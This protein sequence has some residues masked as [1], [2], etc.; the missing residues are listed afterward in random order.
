M[1]P[2][3]IKRIK[4]NNN[5][6][7]NNASKN[8][9]EYTVLTPVDTIDANSE[10]IKT[11]E[12]AIN[13]D[14]VKNIAIAGPY[15]S[16]K[17][18]IIKSYLKKHS[19]RMKKSITISLAAFESESK[20]EDNTPIK[21]EALEKDILRQLF[22]RVDHNKIPQSR[23]HRLHK[24][25]LIGV[26]LFVVF[27]IILLSIFF[28][29]ATKRVMGN[30]QTIGDAV[31]LPLISSIVVFLIMVA[32]AIIPLSKLFIKLFSNVQIKEIK[33]LG[34]TS[35]KNDIAVEAIFD[36]NMDEIMYFFEMTSYDLL[37]FEDLDRF[38]NSEIFVKLREINN[39]LNNDE[40]IKR[41]IVFIYAL[42]DDMFK[43]ED[44]TKF[45]DFIIPVIPVMNPTNSGEYL[46]EK[47]I[48]NSEGQKYNI[49]QNY[50]LDVSP[51]I[52]DM[53]ILHNIFNEFV[54]Y[55]KTLCELQGLHLDDEEMLSM[56]IFKNV[57]PKE[58]ADL[59]AEKGIIKEAFVNVNKRKKE[60]TVKEHDNLLS[61]EKDLADADKEILKNCKE[62]KTSMLSAITDWEGITSKININPNIF[63]PKGTYTIQQ[64][65]ED[66]FD[67][68]LLE[69]GKTI[70][71]EYYTWDRHSNSKAL[72][73][74]VLQDY[75]K[76]LTNYK[77]T[78]NNKQSIQKK[79]EIVK[80]KIHEINSYSMKRLIEEYGVSE[81]LSEEVS[82]NKLLTFLLRRG[83]I[84]ENYANYINFFK[85]Q[86][87]TTDDMN[88]ILS[89]KNQKPLSYDYHLS[90]TEMIISRLQEYEFETRAIYNFDLLNTLLSNRNEDDKK[91]NA[92]FSGL[93]NYDV[94]WDFI[95]QFVH[96]GE[97][98]EAFIC[99]L[100]NKCNNLWDYIYNNSSLTYEKQIDFLRMILEYAALDDI[101]KQNYAESI[102][103]FITE[104]DDT[105]K[106]LF[107]TTK[108]VSLSISKMKSIMDCIHISFY[109]LSLDNV[110]DEIIDYIYDNHFYEI[111]KHM[112]SE[113]VRKK[114]PEL[115]DD[116]Y[117]KNYTTIKKIQY[118]PML[119][120]IDCY[121]DQY[122]DK[123]FF[124]AENTK[125]ES[126]SILYF[127][128][129]YIDN[130]DI[131]CRIITHEE[132]CVADIDEFCVN[133][134]VE[135]DN[136]GYNK[137]IW[138][139]IISERK[140]V[141]NWHNVVTYW[142]RF[143]YND[144]L[145]GYISQN[146][147]MLID[148]DDSE[149]TNEFIADI[150]KNKIDS[151]ALEK[152]LTMQR[153]ELSSIPFDK[154][155]DS[156][157]IV[158]VE[159]NYIPFTLNNFDNLKASHP[160][161]CETLILCHQNEFIQM[162]NEVHIDLSLML[163]LLNNDK[164]Q[165]SCKQKLIDEYAVELMSPELAKHILE[166]NY[167]INK[168]I[169]FEALG[170]LEGQEKKNLFMKN[171]ELF[172]ADDF[173]KCFNTLE[174]YYPEFNDRNKSHDVFIDDTNE[175][176]ALAD[177]LK[178]VSY[179][180]SYNVDK[181]HNQIRCTIKSKVLV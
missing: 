30:A 151:S 172:N 95:D 91:L 75:I 12:W 58:F 88:Y 110:P 82:D 73:N 161:T 113:Y 140:I 53:R 10:Y 32:V 123:V 102:A 46:I 176:I 42:K 179:I 146:V 50:I 107:N 19:D 69:S 65:L 128:P 26:F 52:S 83:Y 160:N 44:R 47:F 72:D 35:I 104:K 111:N 168:E 158:L 4:E 38:N 89:I 108:D 80:N 93:S 6:D 125:E 43:N 138:D 157:I 139:Q 137:K 147:N 180:T 62:I 29:E 162:I 79:I 22:Y 78:A 36:M 25:N 116:I 103:S 74:N 8:T 41:R 169:F 16:G 27:L 177:A 67:L 114:A 40:N 132:F 1:A 57:Y 56:I 170:F 85:A 17:S 143:G 71:V 100:S 14:S 141:S 5:K 135:E 126:D 149:I 18:S 92:F 37:F 2:N 20:I 99:I 59:Q 70:N 68:S 163:R 164:L 77:K 9:M 61:Y 117:I 122:M 106:M 144:I 7:K 145:I 15:G 3:F 130:D 118:Q 159:L 49:S 101:V 90:M 155:P 171:L 33:T 21:I 133:L 173:E 94:S 124:S 28:L 48:N 131:R 81:V 60:F 11:L 45:F 166:N 120:H 64:I 84:N 39:L 51:Y 165:H 142:N 112:I 96:K 98:K 24:I 136:D 148:S 178:K 34:D 76:R 167:S 23:Y 129:K 13:N 181:E 121:L 152:V 86:S 63:Q 54:L 154:I 31:G 87:M 105:L 127:I 109:C 150:V 66:S 115:L 175:N 97:N 134:S 55:K 119:E 156:N 153:Y 174:E